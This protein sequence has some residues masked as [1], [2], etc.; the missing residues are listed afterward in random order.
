[1][2][3]Y[4]SLHSRRQ[5]QQPKEKSTKPLNITTHNQPVKTMVYVGLNVVLA[6]G[7]AATDCLSLVVESPDVFSIAATSSCSVVSRS[8]LDNKQ[9]NE[10]K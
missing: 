2:L 7:M 3:I 4:K 6:A 10:E 8:L 1:M 9:I 5:W